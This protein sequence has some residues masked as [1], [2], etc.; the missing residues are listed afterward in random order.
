MTSTWTPP[1][2][3]T[4]SL[5]AASPTAC[6]TPK[7]AHVGAPVLA[8][9][10]MHT[11]GEDEGGVGAEDDPTV[12][13]VLRWAEACAHPHTLARYGGLAGDDRQVRTGP[14]RALP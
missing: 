10:P 13:W 8:R 7:R 1:T 3:I 12:R 14:R 11:V 4:A 6:T 9:V 5:N 2:P